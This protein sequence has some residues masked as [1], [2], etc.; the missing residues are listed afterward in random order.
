MGAEHPLRDVIQYP[1]K[2]EKN[3]TNTKER[4]VVIT[5]L[6]HLVQKTSAELISQELI[7]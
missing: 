5:F 1:R 7:N 4:A 2:D 6:G 3:D